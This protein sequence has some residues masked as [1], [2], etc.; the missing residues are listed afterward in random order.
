MEGKPA[1]GT[2]IPSR[3]IVHQPKVI[4]IRS[5]PGVRLIRQRAAAGIAHFA[6]GGI[7]H[8][9][10]VAA[11]VDCDAGRAKMVGEGIIQHA[12]H[13]ESA[14]GVVFGDDA[15]CDLISAADVERGDAVHHGFY[16][17]G[18]REKRVANRKTSLQLKACFY[19]SD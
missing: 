14:A 11:W 8:F 6:P 10:F 16:R 4:R 15:A 5:L 3:I 12:A 17:T 1:Y 19:A 2:V 9:G 13:P 18:N 7:T